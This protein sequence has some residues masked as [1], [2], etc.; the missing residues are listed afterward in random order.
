MHRVREVTV[1]EYYLGGSIEP[2][3]PPLATGLY[4]RVYMYMYNHVYSALLITE[5]KST[6][7]RERPHAINKPNSGLESIV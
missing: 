3:E 2:P 6:K 5:R 7:Q 4:I 1:G